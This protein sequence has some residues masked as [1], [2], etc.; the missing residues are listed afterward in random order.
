ML[1]LQV[2]RS[3]RE[4]FCYRGASATE[5][6]LLGETAGRRFLLHDFLLEEAS[7]MYLSATGGS[8]YIIFCKGML[9]LPNFWIEE[10]S[11]TFLFSSKRLLAGRFC[12]VTFC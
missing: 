1:L 8:C 5:C 3:D 9:L 11:A 4:G 12:Y 10:A 7:A 6:F 2:L